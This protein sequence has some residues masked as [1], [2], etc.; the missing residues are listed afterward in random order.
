MAD[1]VLEAV[2]GDSPMTRAWLVLLMALLAGCS[3]HDSALEVRI[4][5]LE[6]Q[7]MDLLKIIDR[8]TRTDNEHTAAINL[9]T[10]AI[11]RNAESITGVIGVVSWRCCGPHE[12][13]RD[14]E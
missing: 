7:Q 1:T 9:H 6:Q 10:D 8:L 11:N 12:R 13:R 3:R 5:M 4:D 2:E 14:R